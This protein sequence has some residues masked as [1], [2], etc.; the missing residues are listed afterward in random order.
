MSEHDGRRGSRPPGVE[1]VP[2]PDSAYYPIFGVNAGAVEEIRG[3]YTANPTSVDHAW[4]TR[5]DE[6]GPARSRPLPPPRADSAAPDAQALPNGAP[7]PG[8]SQGME[9][10][11][12]SVDSAQPQSDDPFAGLRQADRYARVLRLIHFYRARGHRIAD[13]DPLGERASYFPELDPAHYG[14]GKDD[15]DAYFITGD[16]PGDSIQTLREI[17]ARLRAT[18]CRTIGA[19]YT[20]VQDPGR[21]GWLQ[22]LMEKTENKPEIGTREQCQILEQLIAADLFE[23]FVHTKFIGQKRFSLEGADAVV[24]ML[25]S[26]IESAPSLGIREI[27]LGMSH[28]GRLNV[29]C[30]VL[31]KPYE[32]IFNEF[33]D[34]P[35]LNT[36]FGSGDVKYHKGYSTDRYVES[37]ERVH[38][39]LT[40]NPSHL[41]AVNPVVVGRTRAKQVR[42]GDTEGETI[43][44]V[45]LHGDAAFAGQGIVAETLNLSQL[46]GYSTGGTLHIIINNQI[47]FT[48]TPAEARSTLYCSDVAKMIQVPIFHVNGDDPEAA[49]HCVKLAMEYRKRFQDDVVIDLVC[50]RRHGHNEGDEPAFTQPRL[51]SKIRSRP[52]LRQLY[53]D[54]L[55][56]EGAVSTDEVKGAEEKRRADLNRAYGSVGADLPPAGEPYEPNGPWTGYSRTRPEGPTRT[57]VSEARLEEVARGLGNL[58]DYF[59][60]HPKLEALVYRRGRMVEARGSIDWAMAEAFAFGSLLLEGTPVRLSGQDCSRGTFSHRHAVFVDQESGEEY[61]PLNH[62]ADTQA[63]FEVLDSLLSEAAVLG[64]EYGYSLA[65]PGTLT[66]W[67]AQFGDF[68]NGAQVIIDQ[69]ITSAHVKWGRMNG[70]VMLLPHGY[71]GQGPEHSSARV[72]RFLQICAEDCLQVVNCTT[73]AQYFHVLRRQMCRKYRA[74]MV[75]FTPKSLLRAP[76]AASLVEDLS[77]GTFEP[78]LDDTLALADP[79]RVD[80]ILLSFGKIYYELLAASETLPGDGSERV[81][82]VR[83]EEIYP[84]PE[85]RLREIFASYA[86]VKRIFWVQEEP[87]NM[88]AW[89]FVRDR[90]GELMPEGIALEFSGREPS[91]STATGSMRVHRTEQASLI[92]SALEGLA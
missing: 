56:A 10:A 92:E 60:L 18:Y 91:A 54:Q 81:A 72:E 64:F 4:R 36:P 66:L 30:N 37:G 49:V 71:E 21:K 59:H 35:I 24:P 90:L 57:A 41:E 12:A 16:L 19:E 31:G 6:E 17:L 48:T 50:Y 2:E 73:P 47:G 45:L 13:S 33:R 63:H 75:I 86:N 68:S 76:V 89:T 53:A 61:T 84:W 65:D 44:P 27:V 20:H 1:E 14:L 39:T 8:P 62:L 5:F 51:Y 32:E 85:D 46:P 74:P 34:S 83:L 3:R 52:L 38:L 22:A 25:H 87:Q 43:L 23:T 42:A 26:V 88:G 78:V 77:E 55:L 28:R 11:P 29:L 7:E 70:L 69:F 82:L 58:P 79:G 40:S 67:E 9:P 80:R 15:L